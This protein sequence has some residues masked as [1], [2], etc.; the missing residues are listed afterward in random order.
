MN[1]IPNIVRHQL[2]L[3]KNKKLF[4]V[5]DIQ[6]YKKGFEILNKCIKRLDAGSEY[7]L[8]FGH[9]IITESVILDKIYEIIETHLPKKGYISM[10]TASEYPYSVHPITNLIMWRDVVSRLEVSWSTDKVGKL[11][12]KNNY[13]DIPTLIDTKKYRGILSVRKQNVIRDYLFSNNPKILNG[14]TRYVNIT[15]DS[16][17]ETALDREKSTKFPSIHD[18]QTEY[19]QSYF[20][21]VVES[22]RGHTFE[23]SFSQ[24]TE[25]TIMAILNGTMPIILGNKNLISD[26][27][28]MGIKVWNNDFGFN[29]ADNYSNY[30][31]QKC[32]R[33]L[34]IIDKINDMSM[35]SIRDYWINNIDILQKNY[36]IIYTILFDDEFKECKTG[37]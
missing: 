8:M 31:N 13:A 19:K 4:F 7:I 28:K 27:E 6:S 26:L 29:I 20:S 34:E 32:D 3:I 9:E 5:P 36:D 11:F 21:F 15:H 30:S 24:V 2:D 37:L 23:N 14:I 1:H 10:A 16:S 22:E 25:K 35:E 33:F 17:R 12:N 18:L